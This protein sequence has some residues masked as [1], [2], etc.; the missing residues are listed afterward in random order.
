MIFRR[1]WSI[2][3]CLEAVRESQ[4]QV[5]AVELADRASRGRAGA[6]NAAR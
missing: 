2:H 5:F 4:F 1:P 6:H 3:S